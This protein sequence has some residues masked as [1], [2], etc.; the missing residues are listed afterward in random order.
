MQQV[1]SDKLDILRGNR[2][3]AGVAATR[4]G[5]EGRSGTVQVVIV[6]G[7]FFKCCGFLAAGRLFSLSQIGSLVQVTAA[8]ARGNS[9]S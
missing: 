7:V 2:G 5:T 1:G 6:V 9:F 8:G 3:I 4:N